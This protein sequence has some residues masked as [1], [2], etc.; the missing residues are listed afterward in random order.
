MWRVD[1][2]FC[3]GL[4]RHKDP[5]VWVPHHGHCSPARM[6]DARLGDCC[7]LPDSQETQVFILPWLFLFLSLLL[8]CSLT[9]GLIN[10]CAGQLKYIGCD[11]F[12]STDNEEVQKAAPNR[13]KGTFPLAF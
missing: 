2:N 8:N 5:T 4:Q 13:G 6:Q 1:P 12:C 7:L 10:S 11:Q 3:S 9:K